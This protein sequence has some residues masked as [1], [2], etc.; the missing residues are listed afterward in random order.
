M[1]PIRHHGILSVILSHQGKRGISRK[2]SPEPST[3]RMQATDLPAE[4]TDRI[5]DFC[6]DDKGTLSSRA[7]THSS[8]L[9][10]SHFHLFHTVI[11]LGD[12]NITLERATQ[13]VTIV[14]NTPPAVS[15]RFSS[16]L[17]YIKIVEIEPSPTSSLGVQ[18]GD[19]QYITNAVR[20]FGSLDSLPPP[21]VHVSF[22]L[23]IPAPGTAL[24]T[25]LSFIR[26]IVTHVK[27][28]NVTFVR[29]DMMFSFLSSLSQLQ[30]LELS[31]VGFHENTEYSLPGE[32][33]F[34]GVPLS[35]LRITMAPTAIVIPSLVRVATSLSHLE[36]LGIVH[37]QDIRQEELPRL[38]ESIQGTV[39]CP[40]L[41]AGCYPGEWGEHSRSP[42]PDTSEQ[43]NPFCERSDD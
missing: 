22:S 35:T 30:Y 14:R 24:I 1:F 16:P 6:H 23:V 25:A 17:P 38:A 2:Q 28:N 18:L 39:R 34:D 42:A 4:L 3:I 41:S 15:Q 10:A 26:D 5:I 37:Y 27:L 12:R 43:A 21:S 8:W 19:G 40:R 31:G 29:S 36:D 9:P 33:T 20:H 13:L 7:L 32:R 11:S